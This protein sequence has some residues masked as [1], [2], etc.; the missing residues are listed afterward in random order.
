M[1]WWICLLVNGLFV[2]AGCFVVLVVAGV[3]VIVF[4][5]WVLLCGVDV[6]NCY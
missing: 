2:L 5:T 6:D 3:F 4:V 1:I